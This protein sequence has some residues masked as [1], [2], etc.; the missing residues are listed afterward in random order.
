MAPSLSRPS[1]KALKHS[2]V[3]PVPN[4][5]GR[6]RHRRSLLG[7][8]PLTAEAG[9]CRRARPR[10]NQAASARP[11]LA[12]APRPAPGSAPPWG[13]G[14]RA[15]ARS[16][17]PGFSAL[18][19]AGTGGRCRL[20][21]ECEGTQPPLRR[22]HPERLGLLA[23]FLFSL[24]LSLCPLSRSHNAVGFA[25]LKPCCPPV[26]GSYIPRDYRCGCP[27]PLHPGGPGRVDSFCLQKAMSHAVSLAFLLK[28]QDSEAWKKR[29]TSARRQSGL[30][31]N[32]PYVPFLELITLHYDQE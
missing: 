5:D 2:P 25:S 1:Q 3:P 17:S 14:L 24:A 11:S 21:E 20:A 15:P 27:A 19:R 32:L 16:T 9:E 28:I 12:S 8:R 23:L 13:A 4:E 31:Q 6:G 29:Q 26:W 18:R 10:P 22:R 7:P 30:L